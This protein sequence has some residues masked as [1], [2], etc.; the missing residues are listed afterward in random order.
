MTKGNCVWVSPRGIGDNASGFPRT[1][2]RCNFL[3]GVRLMFIARCKGFLMIQSILEGFD[4]HTK[5]TLYQLGPSTGPLQ[6]INTLDSS[7]SARCQ[8]TPPLLHCIDSAGTSGSA[9]LPNLPLTCKHRCLHSMAPRGY[10]AVP[11][12]NMH[13]VMSRHYPHCPPAIHVTFQL[14]AYNG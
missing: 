12:I 1:Q 3:N 2:A 10:H 9:S 7:G 8:W 6:C 13:A 5:V 11:R 14:V 4:P